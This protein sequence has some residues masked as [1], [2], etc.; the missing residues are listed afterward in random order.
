MIDITGGRD[1]MQRLMDVMLAEQET[2]LPKLIASLIESNTSL[3]AAQKQRSLKQ[4]D[5]IAARIIV[6]TRDMIKDMDLPQMVEDIMYPVYDK[7]FTESELRDIV[8]FYKTPTG[9]KT[10]SVMPDLFKD[11]MVA[12]Q[13]ALKPKIDKYIRDSKKAADDEI[14]KMKADK[15]Y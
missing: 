14:E 6:R 10:V 1:N 5:A 12:A 2:E 9:K 3:T 11:S 8:A 15:E 4:S 13:T 7:Y